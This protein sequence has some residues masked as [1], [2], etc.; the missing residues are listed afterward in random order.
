MFCWHIT[1]D[2]AW[3]LRLP[4]APEKF[5]PASVRTQAGRKIWKALIDAGFEALFKST[6]FLNSTFA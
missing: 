3:P 1:A 5:L 4:P 2:A 6:Y